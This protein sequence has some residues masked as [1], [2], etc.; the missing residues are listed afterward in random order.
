MNLQGCFWCKSD[1]P[2]QGREL[3]EPLRMLYNEGLKGPKE[4]VLPR[5]GQQS[6]MPATSQRTVVSEASSTFSYI[7]SSEI[8]PVWLKKRLKE[9]GFFLT[10]CCFNMSSSWA[11]SLKFPWLH[12]IISHISTWHCFVLYIRFVFFPKLLAYYISFLKLLCSSFA[13]WISAAFVIIPGRD[14]WGTDARNEFLLPSA[15][16]DTQRICSSRIFL[17]THEICI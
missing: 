10:A 16:S 11:S 4:S 9:D 2:E 8:A 12:H 13:A 1:D 6:K 3:I 17:L 7:Y 5:F 14:I 15:S